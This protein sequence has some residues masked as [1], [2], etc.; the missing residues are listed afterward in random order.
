VLYVD[1]TDGS[2]RA[3]DE[4]T[5]GGLGLTEATIQRTVLDRPDDEE[6]P[7]GTPEDGAAEP[8]GDQGAP[9]PS[10]PTGSTASPTG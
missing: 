2:L 5:L 8:A 6:A 7:A 10:V 3:Y 1:R 9:A 4:I